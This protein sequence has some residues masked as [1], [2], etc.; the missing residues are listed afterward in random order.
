MANLAS[1]VDGGI[2]FRFYAE[3]A[4]PTSCVTNLI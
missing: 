2:P 3:N 1:E 4:R